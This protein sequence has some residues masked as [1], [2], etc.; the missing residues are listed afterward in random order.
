VDPRAGLDDVEKR[1]FFTLPGFKSDPLVIQAI[2]RCYTDYAIPAPHENNSS[3]NKN[4]REKGE[5]QNNEISALPSRGK[6][7]IQICSLF[8]DAVSN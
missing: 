6:E 3:H 8:N 5:T 1:K 7:V 2:A 4:K